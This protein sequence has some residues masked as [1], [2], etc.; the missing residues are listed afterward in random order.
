MGINITPAVPSRN[1]QRE[2]AAAELQYAMPNEKCHRP[3]LEVNIRNFKPSREV[4]ILAN[5]YKPMP[6]VAILVKKDG[7]E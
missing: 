5:T 6:T 1:H 4:C 3:K 2:T 7:R